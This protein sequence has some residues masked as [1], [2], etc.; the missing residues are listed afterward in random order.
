[1]NTSTGTRTPLDTNILITNDDIDYMRA[2]NP[3]FNFTF[4]SNRHDIWPTDTR[5]YHAFADR[6]VLP[7]PP[8]ALRQ[9]HELMLAWRWEGGRF[10]F[11]LSAGLLVASCGRYPLGCLVRDSEGLW[12]I[13]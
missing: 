13:R 5:G 2:V 8:D 12:G 1:V 11:D 3:R 7:D 9:A 4:S 10:E 6:R